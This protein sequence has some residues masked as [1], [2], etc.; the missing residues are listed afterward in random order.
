MKEVDAQRIS[1]LR[2]AGRILLSDLRPPAEE[3]KDG[4]LDAFH[5]DDD[6]RISGLDMV[7]ETRNP[8]KWIQRMWQLDAECDPPPPGTD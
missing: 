3:V 6:D 1:G 4:M 7:F 8:P 2:I 5:P